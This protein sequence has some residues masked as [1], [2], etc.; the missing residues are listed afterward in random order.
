[1]NTKTNQHTANGNGED[2]NGLVRIDTIQEL[3]E[4]LVKNDAIVEYPETKA[5][6][7]SKTDYDLTIYAVQPGDD[8]LVELGRVL[9]SVVFGWNKTW[10]AAVLN[11]GICFRTLRESETGPGR[12]GIY[13]MPRHH[14]AFGYGNDKHNG[15]LGAGV[16]F[17]DLVAG[18][19]ILT[20][21]NEG[22]C[23]SI[24]L[25]VD[26]RGRKP[27]PFTL[28]VMTEDGRRLWIDSDQVISYHGSAFC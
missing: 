8:R 11:S 13:M 24:V 16:R 6:F 21:F 2:Q 19:K 14:S 7:K 27:R 15:G 4:F 10:C 25:E 26:H 28:C 22:D 9:K 18:A 17:E 1:M 23:M 12:G 20:R 5:A 3:L